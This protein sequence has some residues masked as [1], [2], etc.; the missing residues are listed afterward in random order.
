[1]ASGA[2]YRGGIKGNQFHGQGTL[3]RSNGDY[4][5]GEYRDGKKHGEGELKIGN[6]VYNGPF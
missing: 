6:A 4:Y 1:L 5:K 2:H 3:T